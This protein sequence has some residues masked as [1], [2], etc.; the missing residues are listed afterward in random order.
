MGCGVDR[1]C[2]PDPALLWLWWSPAAA[3]PIQLL[4]WETP[5]ASGTALK[6]VLRMEREEYFL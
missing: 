5:Y 1:R 2:G 4:A 3:A 6:K